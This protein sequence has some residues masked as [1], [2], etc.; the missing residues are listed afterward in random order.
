[1]LSDESK[2]K[3]YDQ[4]LSEDRMAAYYAEIRHERGLDP[5]VGRRTIKTHRHR[6]AG[7]APPKVGALP[8]ILLI[9]LIIV[10]ILLFSFITRIISPSFR[11]SFTQ[12][13]R[14]SSAGGGVITSFEFQDTQDDT[15]TRTSIART[16]RANNPTITPLSPEQYERTADRLLERG[17]VAQAIDTY[18]RAI[19]YAPDDAELYYKRGY[20]YAILYYDGDINVGNAALADFG[21]AIALD[22]AYADVYLERGTLYFVL[23]QQS[24]D[25]NMAQAALADFEAYASLVENVADSVKAALIV[26]RE[27]VGE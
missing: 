23:W 1:M 3:A 25:S 5:D 18:G 13:P 16:Q 4:K 19:L 26:L 20:A 10:A 15:V 7:T 6:R 22:S 24:D 27:T 17:L 9:V 14:V 12:V 21:V 8:W 11:P 2:R